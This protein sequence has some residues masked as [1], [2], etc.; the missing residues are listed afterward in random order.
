VV[1]ARSVEAAKLL[2]A[3]R[4]QAFRQPVAVKLAA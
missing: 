2:Q 1:K 3:Q 4:L